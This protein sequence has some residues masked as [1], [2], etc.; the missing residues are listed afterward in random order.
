MVRIAIAAYA[1]TPGRQPQGCTN[2]IPL[3]FLQADLTVHAVA[4]T[5]VSMQKAVIRASTKT[6]SLHHHAS[7]A[8]QRGNG[9][10][11]NGQLCL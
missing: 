9:S 1:C 5:T 11:Q 4:V 10:I 2:N 3:T 6:V 7:D 8:C